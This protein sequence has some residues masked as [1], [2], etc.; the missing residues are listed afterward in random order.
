MAVR[1]TTAPSPSTDNTAS[2]SAKTVKRSTRTG[3]VKVRRGVSVVDKIAARAATDV[4]FRRVLDL[5]ADLPARPADE[6]VA[7]AARAVNGAR[8]RVMHDEFRAQALT[9]EAARQLLGVARAQN[10]HTARQRG[11]LI[12]QTFG[13]VTY[14]PAWQ[15]DDG[16][17]RSDLAQILQALGRYADDAVIADRVM[18]LPR[19]DLDGRSIIDA[20]DDARL[21][22]TA[23]IVLADSSH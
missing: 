13:N 9:T 11:S 23:W 5:V 3:S 10:L 17:I 8:R 21:G 22:P 18:R 12:G 16:A 19:E 15:F 1:P 4:D 7:Y 20:L 6:P 14:Y 2:K